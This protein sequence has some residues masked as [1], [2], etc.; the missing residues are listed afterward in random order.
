MVDKKKEN[1]TDTVE[2]PEAAEEEKIDKNSEK[3]ILHHMYWSL[4]LGV[5]PLMW[6]D[7]AA[8]IAIQLKMLHRLAKKYEVEFQKK[9]VKSIVVSLL[10][11][12]A[13]G[14]LKRSGLTYFLKSIPIVGVVGAFSMSIYSGGVTYAVG[15]LFDHHFKNGGTF[16]DVD[17]ALFKK[18]FDKL[19]EEGKE[20]AKGL[21]KKK[22]E[23]EA[24]A[25]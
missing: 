5:V 14:A 24:S 17:L 8:L 2:K 3:I 9:A 15:K 22:E 25:A 11:A 18:N 13:A 23:P 21:A 7:L 16:L 1:A 12:G 10:G 6:F 20:K 4:G 19:V